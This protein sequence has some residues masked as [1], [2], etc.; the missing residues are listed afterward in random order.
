MGGTL[1]QARPHGLRAGGTRKMWR[2]QEGHFQWCYF[3]QR[4]DPGA[5]EFRRPA[6]SNLCDAATVENLLSR[7]WISSAPP[8]AV[9]FSVP[10]VFLVDCNLIIALRCNCFL[11]NLSIHITSSQRAASVFN[12]YCNVIRVLVYSAIMIL[13]YR[14][15]KRSSN[16]TCL[17]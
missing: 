7:R 9:F 17:A 16:N 10:D 3:E 8:A 4:V 1:N 15:S 6:A 13:A 14:S 12:M 11:C 2:G 5:I